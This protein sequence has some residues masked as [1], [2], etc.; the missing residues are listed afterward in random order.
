MKIRLV[1]LIIGALFLT[2]YNFVSAEQADYQKEEAVVLAFKEEAMRE[3]FQEIEMRSLLDIAEK[4]GEKS[5]SDLSFEAH[6][7]LD[8]SIIYS[9]N[10]WHVADNVK[11]DLWLYLNPEVRLTLG[12][13]LELYMNKLQ[14]ELELDLGAQITHSFLRSVDLSREA[15]YGRL[16]Y[17]LVGGRNKLNLSHYF[18][19]GYELTSDLAADVE[20][21]TGYQG[22]E[23]RLN[24]EY[25][26]NRFGIGLGYERRA[27]EYAKQYKISNTFED[28]VGIITAFLNLTPKTRVFLEYDFGRYEYTKALTNVSDYDYSELWV[29]ANGK[30]SKKLSGLIKFG[31]EN[32]KYESGTSKNNLMT[33]MA[34]LEY[35]Q[36]SK[37][38]LFLDLSFGSTS[39]G[40]VDLGVDEQKSVELGFLHNFNS[41][42]SFKGD[43]SFV[44]DNYH[45]SQV[46][47]TYGYS[48]TLNYLFQKW[49]KIKLG[50]EYQ[51]RSSTVHTSEY[52]N[53]KYFL[54]TELEF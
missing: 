6:S 30:L 43:F 48:L 23:T 27:N 49:M 5:S 46:D 16:K 45:S 20:G 31:F 19:R 8:T 7:Y 41:K 40:Y 29:G 36:S 22:S 25:S 10:V 15:P 33:I 38:I 42:L 26:F 3:A 28:N 35:K 24:W 2:S 53:N 50:Y 47:N 52:K 11:N 51:D 32:Y 13:F 37:N 17:G 34:D 44:N 18:I 4:D 12:N 1:P 14:Q 39:T 54:G 9:D 21:L